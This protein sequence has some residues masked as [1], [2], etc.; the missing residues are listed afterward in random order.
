MRTTDR[1][2]LIICCLI[3]PVLAQAGVEKAI[4]SPDGAEV[5]QTEP[6]E[7][8]QDASGQWQAVLRLPA[9]ANA[10]SL[11][12]LRVQGTEV[13][14]QGLS[15]RIVR[16]N[17]Q[18]RI[19]DLRNKIEGLKE[20]R[21]HLRAALA[22]I[23]ARIDL[24]HNAVQAVSSSQE[25]IQNEELSRLA[26]RLAQILPSLT[27]DKTDRENKIQETEDRIRDLEQDL[28]QSIDNPESQLE[29]RVQLS[30]SDLQ[31]GHSIPITV[32][33]LLPGSRWRPAYT[34]DARPE[35]DRVDFQWKAMVVQK[36]GL[37]WEDT[38]L[39][40]TTGR[41]RQRVSPPR[42]PE[43]VIQP[44]PHIRPM[45]G[46]DAAREKS[47]ELALGTTQPPKQAARNQGETFDLWDAGHRTIQPGVKQQVHVTKSAWP[48][49]FERILR[50]AVDNQAYL[51]AKI[52]TQSARNIPPGQAMYLVQGR[53]IGQSRFS[54]SGQE[55]D[56]SFGSDPQVTGKR[57]MERK[58]E[59]EQGILKNKQVHTWH[60]RFDVRN[61]KGASV[62]VRLE[63]ASPVS[64]HEDINIDLESPGFDLLI[65]DDTLSWDLTLQ[66]GEKVSVPLQ[67]TV[68]APKD[69]DLSTS[70]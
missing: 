25:G 17:N 1:L 69:M 46:Q 66:A 6:A 23:T 62:Q 4:L 70:R 30:G 49:A 42:L 41:T 40:L 12:I 48:A 58:Q 7:L 67:V 50:P 28:Q 15:H 51:Q 21:D 57:I 39:V 52:E 9:T 27:K 10:D 64:R 68:T 22:G 20:E 3:C 32:S 61:G 11:R 47:Q 36:S 59:G 54:F 16:S 33:Y 53:M 35:L 18:Q 37:V 56:I 43:W 55:I 8:K 44:R 26:S 13:D 14:L 2:L 19:I 38:H 65:D 60:Y 45:L 24:W 29:V 34:L 63:E 5:I 31:A